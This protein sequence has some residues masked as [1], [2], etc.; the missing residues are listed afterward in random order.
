M[1]PQ[2]ASRRSRDRSGSRSRAGLAG[3]PLA[4]RLTALLAAAASCW[5]CWAGCCSFASG[6]LTGSMARIGAPAPDFS[7]TDLDGSPC[8]W[9]S[10]AADR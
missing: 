3:L 8:A 1:A 4:W 10:C 2:P 9:R 6:A 7:L 5:P